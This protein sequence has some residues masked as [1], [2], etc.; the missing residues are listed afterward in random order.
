MNIKKIFSFL[1]ILVIFCIGFSGCFKSEEAQAVDDMILSIGEITLES[2]DAIRRAEKAVRELSEE[3]KKQLDELELLET[4]RATYNS[5]LVEDVENKIEK[6][7]TV[8]IDNKTPI[9]RARTD[10][11]RLTN[12][13][14]DKVKN[15]DVLVA[16]EAELSSLETKNV[17]RL[18][19]E[20]GNVTLKSEKAIKKAENAYKF[21]NTEEKQQITNFSVLEEA[22]KKYTELVEKEGRAAV[23]SLT[24]KYDKVT[25]N[26]FYHASTE[27]VYANKRCYLLPYIGTN[28]S[29]IWLL[30][31]YN[32]TG[33][34]WI[35]FEK[36]T[37]NI[38]GEKHTVTPYY[39]DIIHHVGYS[40]VVERYDVSAKSYDIDM[41]KKI[42]FSDETIV[43]LQ[44]DDY[45][46]DFTVKQSDKTAIAEVL[47]AYEYMLSH[48]EDFTK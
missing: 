37:I 38:D 19:D 6:I 11:D 48:S 40:N 30:I 39:N 42:A 23:K 13:L 14:K 18:I 2:R 45:H 24:K 43:R 34:S 28:S 10:Y 32:Y 41:L 3:D 31:R 5:L 9:R 1:I 47:T 22:L 21:L 25:E 20:I 29:D 44:G 33:E 17:I 35:F 15:Y 46:K 12:E 27:P 8:K 16:A 36:I 4:H 7:G 26:T